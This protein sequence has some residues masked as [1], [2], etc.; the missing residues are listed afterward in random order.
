MCRYRFSGGRVD[1]LLFQ[2]CNVDV[3]TIDYFKELS[4]NSEKASKVVDIIVQEKK[5]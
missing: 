1:G 5:N 2:K 4:R 3:D